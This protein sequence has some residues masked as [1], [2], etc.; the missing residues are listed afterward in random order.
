MQLHLHKIKNQKGGLLIESLVS[1]LIIS[2][3]AM[4][5]IQVS[6]MYSDNKRQVNNQSGR[7][8]TVDFIVGTANSA[9]ALYWA[10]TL[11]G[12]GNTAL[13]DCLLGTSS[14]T[15]CSALSGGMPQKQPLSLYAV[16][17]DLKISSSALGPSTVFL[18]KDSPEVCPG[19]T[20]ANEACPISVRTT[21][22]AI[23]PMNASSCKQAQAIQVNYEIENVSN[24]IRKVTGETIIQSQQASLLKTQDNT[25]PT[26]PSTNSGCL[27]NEVSVGFDGVGNL[28]C[29]NIENICPP[30]TIVVGVD[31]YG[32]PITSLLSATEGTGKYDS[33]AV[34]HIQCV[35]L[36]C[37]GALLIG[38]NKQATPNILANCFS[39]SISCSATSAEVLMDVTANATPECATLASCSAANPDGTQIGQNNFTQDFAGG[40]NV[41]LTG[42]TGGVNST[43]KPFGC[44]INMYMSSWDAYNNCASITGTTPPSTTVTVTTTSTSTTTSTIPGSTT[45]TSSTTTTTLPCPSPRS[46]I[47]GICRCPAPLTYLP[48]TN[49]CLDCSLPVNSVTC[50]LCPIGATYDNATDTCIC[51]DPNE[52]YDDVALDCHSAV[53]YTLS[54]DYRMTINKTV[55]PSSK[56]ACAKFTFTTKVWVKKGTPKVVEL[57]RSSGNTDV[58]VVYNGA[59]VGCDIPWP[60]TRVGTNSSCMEVI[61]SRTPVPY[62][63]LEITYNGNGSYSLN[64]LDV[65]TST[66]ESGSQNFATAICVPP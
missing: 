23:C 26:D 13:K 40:Y 55:P 36:T 21:F 8:Q 30:G 24:Q 15:G 53:S 28:I 16:N 25:T 61:Q 32:R 58:S 3:A 33:T 1:V 47:G 44:G 43:C 63:R 12:T 52:Y 20:V 18:K 4:S 11:P 42:T 14:N 27:D 60:N 45:T 17:Q 41:A 10:A 2:I 51:T 56:T 39:T 31:K 29:Q 48:D 65:G 19:V 54:E 59:P 57:D 34:N 37:A 5:A 49:E 50:D 6:S 62:A 9:A 7:N 38:V 22:T 64:F 35:P 46:I 66:G